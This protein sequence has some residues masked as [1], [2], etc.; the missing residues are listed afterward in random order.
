[1]S[2]D[3]LFRNKRDFINDFD[4]G[5]N[6]AQV[7][8]DM[9]NRSVPFYSEIQRMMA[10]MAAYFAV[11]HTNL[12]DLGCSTGET[13]LLLEQQVPPDVTFIGVDSSEDM[14]EKARKKLEEANISHKYE[15][16]QSDLNQGVNIENASVVIMNLT[17]QF[18]RPLYREKIVRS[19]AEGIHENGCFIVVE[20]VLSPNSLVNRLFIKLYYDFKKRSGYNE[21]EIK[22]KREALENVLIPYHYDENRQLLLKSGFKSCECFFR[23][24]NFCGILAVK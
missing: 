14:L 13:F 17:L 23:W 1:M 3:E 6:T 22:Q 10:E 20:K 11:E 12:Y 19:I 5:K 15:L 9:L 24:Y 2:H 16:I 8:D 18:I 21:L 4:F 7:F